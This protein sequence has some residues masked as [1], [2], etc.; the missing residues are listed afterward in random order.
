VAADVEQVERSWIAGERSALD[1]GPRLPCLEPAT[2][3]ALC[4]VAA[5][6]AAGVDAAVAAARDG[7]RVWAAT[8]PTERARVLWRA[9]EELRGSAEDLARLEVRDTGKPI[10]EARSYD[11][12]SAVEVLEFFAGVPPLV[13]GEHGDVGGGASF[14]T[15]REPVGV[16]AGV[17]AWNY[18]LQIAA[19]KLAP[20]LA[21]GNAVVLKPSALTP[22]A[23][24]RLVQTLEAAGLPP[25]VAN[26]V[27]GGDAE[28]RA[29]VRHPDVAKVS[30]TGGVPTGKAVLAD[31]APTLKRV[32][33]E[34]G[35]KSPLLVFGDADLERAVDVALLAN[36]GCQ[37]EV[38]TNAARVYVEAPLHDAFL[39]R[40]LARLEAGVR[41]GD[42]LDPATNVGALISA[43]H[44]ERVAGFVA[45][46]AAD[47]A[48]ERVVGR[49]PE[50]PA[51]TG[52]FFFAPRVFSGCRDDME[53]VREEVFGPVLALLPFADEDE[54]VRR[55]NAT[56]YGLAA[57]VV[58][59][60]LSRAHRVAARLDAGIVW[61]NGY[62]ATPIAMPFGGVKES[63]L[64]RENGLA[65]VEHFTRLKSVHL[66]LGPLE[67]P[68]PPPEGA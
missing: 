25:G 52:G 44:R 45:R 9:A 15:R 3:R 65:A 68:F 29:L 64:G 26:V 17:C 62:N 21:C 50:D 48:V 56:P 13:R 41:I 32:T 2:G 51:L 39:E 53:L 35:G 47:G 37:G 38:C 55:A 57:G 27:L 16:V 31:A 12:P 20:A 42:P 7:L 24:V 34:L 67:P 63:G 11:V 49:L 59:S 1:D 8:P 28:G 40:L 46:A 5:A 14:Y 54:A 60:D 43:A 18:P 58:T 10:A 61:V 4:E 33:L 36:F 23:T 66:E 30:L 6:G 19:W 22:L